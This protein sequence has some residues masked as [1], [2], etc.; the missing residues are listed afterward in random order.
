MFAEKVSK[1]VQSECPICLLVL[2]EPYQATCCGK[3]F[4]KKCIHRVKANLKP[5]PTCKDDNFKLFHSAP[6]GLTVLVMT[7][8]SYSTIK[9]CS[10][11]STIF[12][13][14]ARI[15]A[16]AVNGRES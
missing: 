7:I 3:S 5:C 8:L 9:D 4:C 13:F 15:R 16:K 11:R 6:T 1:G 14:T 12:K 2:R 10:S